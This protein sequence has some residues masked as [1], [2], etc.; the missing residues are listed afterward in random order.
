MITME[1]LEEIFKNNE[2]FLISTHVLPDGDGI[3][4]ELA[5]AGYLKQLGKKIKILNHDQTPAKFRYLDKSSW[6]EVCEVKSEKKLSIKEPDVLVL[7]DCGDISRIGNVANVVKNFKSRLLVFDHHINNLVKSNEHFIDTKASSI[8][9]MLYRYLSYVDANIT[10]EMAQ[11][12]YVSILTDTSSFRH[13]RTTALSHIIAASLIDLGVNPEETYQKIYATDSIAKIRLLGEVLNGI[14]VEADGRFAWS[15]ITK[16]LRKK[17]GATDDDP[18]SFIDLFLLIETVE[19]AALIREDD[20]NAIKVSFRSK[21]EFDVFQIAQELGGGGHNYAA[22]AN[23]SGSIESVI[24]NVVEK[25]KKVLKNG[26]K[27]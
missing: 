20:N 8:G 11:A 5:I 25:C 12:L 4:G 7:V 18:S 2:S 24:K 22:G 1:K 14:N 21:G 13:S 15:A 27:K 9:E 6:I 16:G 10:F 26:A 17:Y 3:G 23:M 19:I